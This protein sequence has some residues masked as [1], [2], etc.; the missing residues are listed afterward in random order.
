MIALVTRQAQSIIH[1]APRRVESGPHFAANDSGVQ[2]ASDARNLTEV[3]LELQLSRS[4]REWPRLMRFMVEAFPG[5]HSLS[6][7]RD[8]TVGG[9]QMR[10]TPAIYFDNDPETP[11][12][13]EQCG[14][15]VEQLLAFATAIITAPHP[16]LVLVDEPQAYLHPHAESSLLRLF[17]EHPQHQYVIATH[18]HQLLRA[19]PLSHARLLTLHEGST[20]I[21]APSEPQQVLDELGVTAADLWLTDRLLWVEGDTEAEV[22][23]ILVDERLSAADAIGLEVRPM[24][25]AASRFTAKSSKQAE[26][27]YRFCEQIVAAVGVLPV[28]MRFLFDRDEKTEDQIER[29]QSASRDKAI[30]LSVRE[31]ENLF[32]HGELLEL[33]IAERC[34]ELDL[35][36]PE[37]GAV[38][39]ALGRLLGQTGSTELFP[40]GPPSD[41]EAVSAAKGSAMLSALYTE[42]TGTAYEKVADGRALARIAVVN[43]PG[44]LQP[45]VD[46]IQV[47]H[48][49]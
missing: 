44:L 33:A 34:D 42:F 17:E 32:L 36:G 30:F 41:I 9:G 1:I 5:L 15:G 2:L 3:L 31:I 28:R 37:P 45:L 14:T 7:V 49:R 8:S 4:T 27:T 6:M 21:T 43:M 48:D 46:V 40:A 47:L 11:I 10:V 16:R 12:P 39:Q 23:K 25:D 19:R 18:S 22:F 29:I 24:P 38:A 35:P 13:L 20:V 26:A